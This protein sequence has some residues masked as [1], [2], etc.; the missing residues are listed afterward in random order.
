MEEYD[1]FVIARAVHVLGVVLWIGG[2]AFVTTILIPAVKQIAS[3]QERLELFEQLE[4][5]FS[6][7]A[8]FVTL[9]TGISGYVMLDIING[10]D[11]YLHPQFWWMHLMTLVW[12]MF[13][14]VL[15]VFEPLFLHKWF[16][17]QAVIDSEKTFNLIHKMHIFLL[18]LSLIAVAGAVA[19]SHGYAF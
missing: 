18:S 13:T 1:Y 10:W 11:R 4:S 17:E 14:L 12:L 16:H 8:K 2:V 5:K 3:P 6:F 7:Q 19:G 9:A 15:F